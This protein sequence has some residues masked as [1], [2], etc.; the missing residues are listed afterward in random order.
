M[1]KHSQ[2]LA[3]QKYS[4]RGKKESVSNCF[5]T[6]NCL[7]QFFIIT[8]PGE[9]RGRVIGTNVLVCEVT[10]SRSPDSQRDSGGDV[11]CL[12][13][14][15]HH[16]LPLN[17]TIDLVATLVTEESS[18]TPQHVKGEAVPVVSMSSLV[19]RECKNPN[20]FFIIYAL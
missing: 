18:S 1:K 13:Q 8:Y 3:S 12:M 4:T 6:F 17:R 14:A 19:I 9:H 16:K 5:L 15:G 11:R 10:V 7:Q 2:R 20:F